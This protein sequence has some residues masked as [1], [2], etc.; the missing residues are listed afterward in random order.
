MEGSAAQPSST[1]GISTSQTGLVNAISTDSVCMTIT[2]RGN[3]AATEPAS[4]GAVAHDAEKKR[5][6]ERAG[7]L[8]RGDRHADLGEVHRQ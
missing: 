3:A 4:A 7:N 8:P 5:L 2:A 1:N 6:A